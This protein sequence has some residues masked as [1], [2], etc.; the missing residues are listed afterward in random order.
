MTS[1]ERVL[2]AFRKQETDRVPVCHVSFS[3]KVASALL[4]REAC[5]GF[6]IQQWREATALWNGADAHREFI[7]RT[8]QDTLEINRLCGNDIYR[9]AYPRYGVK[10]TKRIDAN[11]FLYEYGPEENWKVLRYDPQQE[12]INVLFDYRPRPERTFEDLERGLTAREQALRTPPKPPAFSDD[13]LSVRAQRLL[14]DQCVIRM[15]G[16]SVSIPRDE[17]WLEAVALRPDLVARSLDL[18]VESARRTVGPLVEFGFRYLFGGGDFAGYKGP[19]YSPRA[20]RELVL[21]RLRQVTEIIH[22]HGGY[23]LFASDGDLW[24]VAEDL[25][26]RSGVDGFYEIDRRAGMDLKRLRERFPGLTLIGNIHSCTLHR[27]SREEV[28]A[29]TLSCLEAARQHRGILVGISNL[30]M[31]GTPTENVMAMLETIE[32]YR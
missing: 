31:P 20:F 30:P 13:D 6:G 10:P 26:G 3:S 9:M 21:P 25:F 16:G 17:V 12:H 15:G 14:G 8:F 32:K 5:V 24:P 28:V 22:S 18:Q 4:G 11:T 7:E 19:F 29:E 2:A 1:K 27:G 23:S